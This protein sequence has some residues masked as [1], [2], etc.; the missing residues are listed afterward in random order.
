MRQILPVLLL[1]T[2][3]ATAQIAADGRANVQ[4]ARTA[5]VEAEPS[6]YRPEFR[7]AIID[8]RVQV[9]MTQTEAEAAWFGY[10]RVD[11]NRTTTAA[12][13]REQHVYE[14]FEDGRMQRRYFYLENGRVV[15]VQ[16]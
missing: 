11:V 15:A 4:R 12:G 5:L 2:G 13:T 7:Q 10:R 16:D 6:K 8:G 3:C 14:R 1:V 9:G